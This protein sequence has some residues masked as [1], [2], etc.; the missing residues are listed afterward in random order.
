MAR[1]YLHGQMDENMK[2]NIKMIKSMEKEYIHGPMVEYMLAN[3]N[4]IKDMDLDDI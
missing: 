3:G 1:V 4:M 2:A